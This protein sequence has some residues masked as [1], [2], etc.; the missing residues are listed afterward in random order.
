MKITKNLEWIR[1]Y[2]MCVEH[3]IPKLQQ[4]KKVS[5]CKGSRE[6]YQHFH[7]LITYYD[8]KSFRI[9]IYVSYH[10]PISDKIKNYSTMDI[11]QYLSH[12]LAHLEHWEHTTDHKKLE[13]EIMMIFTHILEERGYISEEAEEKSK[14]FYQLETA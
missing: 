4:L 1:E 9:S 7:G 10:D 11:L 13:C 14:P 5:S 2:I 3:L 6:R 8:K 12:E